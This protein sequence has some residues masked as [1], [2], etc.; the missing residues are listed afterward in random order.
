MNK[1]IDNKFMEHFQHDLFTNLKSPGCLKEKKS[2]MQQYFKNNAIYY[3]AILI[4]GA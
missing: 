3:N 2:T 4:K 1:N